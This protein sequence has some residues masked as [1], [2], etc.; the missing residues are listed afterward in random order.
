VSRDFN[1]FPVPALNNVA[2]RAGRNPRATVFVPSSSGSLIVCPTA[3]ANGDLYIEQQPSALLQRNALPEVLGQSVWEAL[4]S[5][6]SFS[7]PVNLRA[8]K[9]TDW[10]AFRASGM[11]TVR[12]FED[13]FVRVSV[14]AFPCNLRIES[15]RSG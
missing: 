12:Q 1:G 15:R 14:E 7:E 4:L 6:R 11:K 10:P 9:K 2:Q 13:S 3:D 8:H 5:F